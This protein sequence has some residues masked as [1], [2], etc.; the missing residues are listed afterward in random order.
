MNTTEPKF[1]AP[2]PLDELLDRG[3]DLQAYYEAWGWD[4]DH[5][6]WEALI[7]FVL[8]SPDDPVAAETASPPEPRVGDAPGQRPSRRPPL[9]P[10]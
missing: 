6:V 1:K 5:D 3:A 2:E 10:G 8:I 4:P 7:D 9:R